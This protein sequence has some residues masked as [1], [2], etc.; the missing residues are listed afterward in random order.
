M[1]A[2]AKPEGAVVFINAQW[3]KLGLRG[4]VFM[5]VEDEWIRSTMQAE[6]LKKEWMK[7]FDKLL[8]NRYKEVFGLFSGVGW[9]KLEPRYAFNRIIKPKIREAG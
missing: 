2:H 4:L 1:S 3:Y 6:E 8:K 7:Q 5:H 9:S